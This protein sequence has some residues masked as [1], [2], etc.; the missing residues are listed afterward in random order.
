MHINITIPTLNR[1][2]GPLQRAIEGALG[3]THIHLSVTVVDDGSTDG[4]LGVLRSYASEPR[5]QAIRLGENVGTAR[6]KNVGLLLSRYDAITFHDSD[7]VPHMDKAMLQ[8]RAME[9]HGLTA[10][11]IMDWATAGLEPQSA[12]KVDVVHGAYDL[13]KL[14]GSVIRIDRNITLVDDFFPQLQF[15]SRCI[16][17]WILPNAALYRRCVFDSLGGYLASIE[18]D[19]ELRNRVLAAGHVHWFVREPLITKYEMPDS[20][21][22]AQETN[23]RAAQRK[24]D[25]DEVWRR[26]RR[27]AEGL[28]GPRV[29]KEMVVPIELSDLR[30][31]ELI[32]P[33]GF[34]LQTSIP[35]TE[36]THAHLAGYFSSSVTEP[37]AAE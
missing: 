31:E 6:A 21:T 8:G 7:D 20:L 25:R 5:F 10:D 29:A 35:M 28:R 9:I 33:D 32:R 16:G 4:T 22:V 11:P 36:A 17:D 3:Q 19:R 26:S 18:E 13:V 37:L 14:D 12:L 2:D 15:P 30:I 23:Y 34:E 24:R 27:Y 1:A